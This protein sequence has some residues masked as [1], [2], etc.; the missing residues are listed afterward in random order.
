MDFIFDA[1]KPSGKQTK[2][3]EKVPPYV[4]VYDGETLYLPF[5]G[6]YFEFLRACE[7]ELKIHRLNQENLERVH[8]LAQRTNQ[9]N[10]STM[11]YFSLILKICA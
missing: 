1:E 10:F 11:E 3:D 8:E 4:P 7:I 6:D 9:M 5:D 2:M